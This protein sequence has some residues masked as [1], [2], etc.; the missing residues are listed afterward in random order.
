MAGFVGF[1]IIVASLESKEKAKET[2]P[3]A[4][5]SYAEVRWK[6]VGGNLGA[7]EDPRLKEYMELNIV[8]PRFRWRKECP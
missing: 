8:L 4:N 1:S 7:A 3:K 5:G 6:A 2:D